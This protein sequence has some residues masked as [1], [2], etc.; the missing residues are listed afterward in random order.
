MKRAI[1]AFLT[2]AAATVL[3]TDAATAAKAAARGPFVFTCVGD[4]AG[5]LTVTFLG[6]KADRARLSYQGETVVASHALSADGGLYTAEDVEFWN[7]GDDG[8]LEWR[9]DK[10]KCSL[11]K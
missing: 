9:G 6:A 1:L 4:S 8:V 5:T 7:K 2:C 3:L 11:N 10:A